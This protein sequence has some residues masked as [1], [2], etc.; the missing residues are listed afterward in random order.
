MKG[1]TTIQEADVQP[2]WI[3]THKLGQVELLGFENFTVRLK[4]VKHKIIFFVIDRY[5]WIPM[6]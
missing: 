1:I 5:L 6:S 4:P 3:D 2:L